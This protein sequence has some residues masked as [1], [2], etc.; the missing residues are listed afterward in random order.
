MLNLELTSASL[1]LGKLDDLESTLDAAL[2][3][4][5]LKQQPSTEQPSHE[6]FTSRDHESIEPSLVA[7]SPAIDA[8]PFPAMVKTPPTLQSP[9]GNSHSTNLSPPKA[10]S[11][12]SPTHLKE[13]QRIL[14]TISETLVSTEKARTSPFGSRS[15]GGL[16]NDLERQ[17]ADAKAKLALAERTIVSVD[18]H[19][20]YVALD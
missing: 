8:A 11:I 15:E 14:F 13:S 4:L 1:I 19:E 9:S 16:M 12:L 3:C 17:L 20:N 10:A 7:A 2:Q 5:R 6:S 18:P